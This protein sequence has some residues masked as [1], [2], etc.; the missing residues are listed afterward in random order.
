MG[1]TLLET[2]FAGTTGGVRRKSH[3]P[4]FKCPDEL[5][6]ALKRAGFDVLITANN[7]CMDFG[8]RGLRR[9]LR[10]LNQNGIEHTGTFQSVRETRENLIKNIK[11]IKIGILS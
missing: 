5:A 9:T 7:H 4:L 2:T 6:P 1:L 8:V 11:G 3:G 10:I